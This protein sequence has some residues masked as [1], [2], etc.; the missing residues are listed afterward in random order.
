MDAAETL[1]TIAATWLVVDF[2]S[3]VVH[4]AEDS[5]GSPSA[6]FIGRR[7]TKPNVLHKAS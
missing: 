7:I 5:Y 4:W 6:T 2:I 3:G 1:L